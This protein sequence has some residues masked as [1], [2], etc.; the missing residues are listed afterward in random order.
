MTESMAHAVD[1]EDNVRNR[2]WMAVCV[3]MVARFGRSVM[4]PPTL[5]GST[6]SFT[7][8]S[9]TTASVCLDCIHHAFFPK[10]SYPALSPP[11]KRSRRLA[12]SMSC[13]N[14]NHD[15]DEKGVEHEGA[16]HLL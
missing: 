16:E 3:L 2:V 15:S 5:S 4:S 14:E 8:R 6:L 9:T 10:I 7:P 11:V 13:L 1:R 12:S